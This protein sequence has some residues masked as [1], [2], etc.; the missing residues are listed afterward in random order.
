MTEQDR[1]PPSTQLSPRATTTS[2]TWQA[3]GSVPLAEIAAERRRATLLYQATLT[4][5]IG[6]VVAASTYTLFYLLIGA[7]QILAEVGFVAVALVFAAI[8][9]VLIRRGRFDAASYCLFCGVLVAYG[10]GELLLG[11][12]TLYFTGG[13]ILLLIVVGSLILPRKWGVWLLLVGLFGVYAG[14]INWFRPLPRY[15]IT[16]SALLH[17]VTLGVT[18]LVVLA[19]LWQVVRAFRIGTIRTRLLLSFVGLTLLL[20]IVL[21][22]SVIAVGT[23]AV[24]QQMQSHLESVAVL[25]EAEIESW[26]DTLQ[27]DLDLVLAGEDTLRRVRV[28]LMGTPSIVYLTETHYALQEHFKQA[29]SRTGRFDELFLMNLDGDVILSTDPTKE[30]VG[31]HSIERYFRQGLQGPYINPPFYSLILGRNTITVSRP[32][33]DEQGRVIGVIAGHA[34]LAVLDR[35]M[36]ERA[37]L[38]LTGETYLV[39]DLQISLTA[40][41]LGAK[42]IY[43][44]SLGVDQAIRNRVNGAALYNNYRGEPVVGAYHWLPR[45]E[46]ALLAE[47][48]QAEAFRPVILSLGVIGAITL[49]LLA[50]AAGASLLLTRSIARPLAQLAQTATQIAGGD[51][52]Q[53]APVLRADETGALAEAF[54]RMTAQLR[55]LIGSLEQRVADRTRE[56]AQ[57]SAYLEAAAE[58][59]RAAISI[60]E[61]DALIRQVVELIRERFDLYYVGLFLLDETGEWAVLRAGTGEAGQIMMQRGHRRRI[62]E[63]MIG[64]SIA[65]DQARV[66]VDV[67]EDAVR[68]ATAELPLTRSEAALPLHSRGRVLGALSVQS[69]RP[70]A[71]DSDAL[72]VLQTVADQVAVALDNARLF[73]E[74]QE[75]LAAVQRAYGELSR[76]AWVQL[77]RARSD[78]GYRSDERGVTEAGR[79]W[80]PALERV[81]RTGQSVRGVAEPDEPVD[82]PEKQS[83]AVPIRVGGDVIG[84]LGTYKPAEAGDWTSEEI[85]LLEAMSSQLGLALES[86][87][88]YQDSQRR[89]I[90]EQLIGEITRRMRETLDV[91]T[92]LRTATNEIYEALKLDE[93]VLRLTPQE[94]GPLAGIVASLPLLP[95]KRPCAGRDAANAITLA[96]EEANYRAGDL[97]VKLEIWDNSGPQDDL[98]Q[99][100]LEAANAT[101]AV[102]DPEVLVYLGPLVSAACAVSLPILSRGGL[103]QIEIGATYPGLTRPGFG[104]GEPDIY[105]PTGARTFFRLPATDD[106]QGPAGAW[107]ACDLGLRRVYVVE[108]DDAYGRALSQGF[109]QAADAAGLTIVGHS[110]VADGQTTGLDPVAADVAARR[111]DAVYYTGFETT[112]I[113]LVEALHAHG[114]TAALIGADGLYV[115]TLIERLGSQA[116]GLRATFP[117]ISVA[118]LG[119]RGQDFARRFRQRFG[120]EPGGWAALAYDGAHIA[121]TAIGQAGRLD[122]AA[123]IQALHEMDFQGLAGRYRFDEHGD[124][125]PALVSGVQVQGGRW[126]PRGRLRVSM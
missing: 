72:I 107:W 57:R 64:W 56:L 101:R 60:L 12:A 90:R 38:G 39:S 8:A 125:Q 124:A 70:A 2:A 41:R 92:V 43:V 44:S 87:R 82:R 126:Q 115:S 122:R 95:E 73:A 5:V 103:A 26:L 28:L 18:F 80:S 93:V 85:D 49:F 106:V 36:G 3:V 40:N 91:D 100:V 78:L 33:V 45:L 29:I 65:H 19:I 89:A 21:S 121:L 123:V 34:N 25:K 120:Y 22:G 81:W 32:V 99:P 9:Y 54:N 83:L 76:E 47:Q 68:L 112:G 75:A 59:G 109:R 116:E 67:G 84:V 10:G 30:H 97:V 86:A 31:Y 61:A 102:A 52:D 23:L 37:G 27:S 108:Q 1:V 63:G 113:A 6:A 50:L 4:L 66:A 58:V 69:D 118:D 62:G 74:S 46:V 94:P 7:W 16:Q 98:W 15:D 114:V 104:E 24:Q 11:N 35:I 55:G 110:R 53:A 119:A 42:Y 13:G 14:L 77:L 51:L 17:T 20:T 117:G 48:T 88:L 79:F 105:Y 111:P 71:F 96:V